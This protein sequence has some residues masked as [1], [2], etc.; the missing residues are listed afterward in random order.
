MTKAEF[1]N[2]IVE[3]LGVSF[4]E[5]Y[6]AGDLLIEKI[7]ASISQNQSLEIKNFGKFSKMENKEN[8]IVFI[9]NISENPI[10]ITFEIKNPKSKNELDEDTAFSLGVG[11]P[12]IPLKKDDEWGGESDIS[13]TILKKSLGERINEYLSKSIIKGINGNNSHRGESSAFLNYTLEDEDKENEFDSSNSDRDLINLLNDFSEMSNPDS[14]IKV[15]EDSSSPENENEFD[16]ILKSML[17]ERDD[18]ENYSPPE[19][20]E[21]DENEKEDPITWDW[22]DELKKEIALETELEEDDDSLIINEPEHEAKFIE[23]N[24]EDLFEKLAKTIQQSE[25]DINEIKKNYDYEEE[26]DFIEEDED[27]DKEFLSKD[28]ELENEEESDTDFY[29]DQFRNTN[30]KSFELTNTAQNGTQTDRYKEKSNKEPIYNKKIITIIGLL[31]L[32]SV[33]VGVGYYFLFMN[34]QTSEDLIVEQKLEDP[35]EIK[36]DTT[37]IPKNSTDLNDIPTERKTVIAQ[38]PPSTRVDQ[39]IGNDTKTSMDQKVANLIFFDGSNYNVQVSSWRNQAKAIGE[40]DRL[41]KQGL[42][43]FVMEAYLPE[44]GG[45]WYRVRVGNFK[46]INEA[47]S[48]LSKQN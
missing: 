4:S 27:D 25:S 26:Q 40:V 45:T 12:L 10:K 17:A 3:F 11:K 2:K 21:L 23:N 8:S 38:K 43:A 1:Y 19:P 37:I 36:I 47:K 48:F 44:K 18:N 20:T 34:K 24:K 5:R 16:Q 29:D 33:I 13:L 32:F 30:N 9:D 7:A 41:K 14:L 6:L 22:G 31:I 15:E 42:V 39:K 28:A 35:V 46:S